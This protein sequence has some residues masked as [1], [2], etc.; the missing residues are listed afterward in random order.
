MYKKSFYSSI[1]KVGVEQAMGE[2]LYSIKKFIQRGGIYDWK[3]EM[4]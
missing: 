2:C 4:R 1:L 3:S